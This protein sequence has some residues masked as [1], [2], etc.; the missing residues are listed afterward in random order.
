MRA[1]SLIMAYN[2]HNQHCGLR[3]DGCEG[4]IFKGNGRF[5]AY[6]YKMLLCA[7]CYEIW[8]QRNSEGKKKA[9][10]KR[11]LKNLRDIQPTLFDQ[12]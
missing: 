8:L 5:V 7:S 6:P 12:E 11:N 9:S 10:D 2:H 3:A 1:A 4:F